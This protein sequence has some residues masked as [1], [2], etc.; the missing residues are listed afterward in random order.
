MG[1]GADEPDEMLVTRFLGGD[2]AA[3]DRLAERYAAPVY[4][5]VCWT[6]NETDAEDLAQDVFVA[7]HQ[8]L[9]SWRRRSSFRTWLYGVARNVCRRHLRDRNVRA[10]LVDLGGDPEATLDPA[11]GPLQ[12][13]HGEEQNAAM[14]AAIDQLSPEH[15]VTLML[16][17]W[18]GMSYADIAEVTGVPR[19]TVR[20]RLHNA[21]AAVAAKLGERP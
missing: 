2:R 1:T 12:A 6:V 7:A 20:S 17:G 11:P 21:R 16:R 5:F 4:R 15:R 10:R 8:S 19:G 14:L 9:S 13:L 18:E 3:F